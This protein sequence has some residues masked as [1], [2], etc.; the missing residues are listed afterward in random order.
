MKLKMKSTLALLLVAVL[1]LTAAVPVFAAD[2]LPS[3]AVLVT[4]SNIIKPD[5]FKII[6]HRG[7][8]ACA[9]E[10]TLAAFKLAG[11]CGCDG[12]RV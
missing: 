1:L 4:K 8:S 3:G 2:E 9:P 6:A 12:R 11:R 7:L 5:E 10:N